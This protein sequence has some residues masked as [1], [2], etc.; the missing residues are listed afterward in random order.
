MMD[1]VPLDLIYQAAALIKN[2]HHVV[3]FTGAGISTSSGVPDFRSI[4]TGLWEKNDPMEVATLSTFR[5]HPQVFFNWL[6]PLAKS[7]YQAVPN[8]AHH[9]LAALEQK[10][11]LKSIITQNIDC[12]HQKAGT[13]TIY[14][15]HGSLDMMHCLKCG[16]KYP[17]ERYITAFIERSEL[18][19]CDFCHQLLKPGIVLFEEMLPQSVWDQALHECECADVIIII[20]SSLEVSPANQLPLSGFRHGAHLIINNYTPTFLDEDARVIIQSNAAKVIPEIA[21]L[22]I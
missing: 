3:A 4:G 11:Y 14:E 13:K 17:S 12:L 20:G 16:G 2:A 22:L 7:I 18:P 5:T 9:A 15:V 1:E 19:Y 8:A 6:K 10:G 21:G